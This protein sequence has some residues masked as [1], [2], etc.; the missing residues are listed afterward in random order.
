[1]DVLTLALPERVGRVDE[2]SAATLALALR[3]AGA[4]LLELNARDLATDA[5][6]GA[7]GA[8]GAAGRRG[9]ALYDTAGGAGHA[10]ELL[11]LGRPWLGRARDLMFVDAAHDANCRTAC[12]R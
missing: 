11:G 3:L 6:T 12:L 8:T 9:V 10:L 5:A 4:E 7:T 1:M 2:P